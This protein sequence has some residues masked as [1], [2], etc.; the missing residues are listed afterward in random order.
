MKIVSR[1]TWN[2]KNVEELFILMEIRTFR[3]SMQEITAMKYL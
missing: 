2:K 1:M 3:H